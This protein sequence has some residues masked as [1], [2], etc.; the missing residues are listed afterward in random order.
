MTLDPNATTAAKLD[1]LERKI[2]SIAR[3]SQR[4]NTLT[5]IFGVISTVLVGYWLYHAHSRFSNEVNPQLV[6][7]VGQKYIEDYLPSASA[8]LQ[9]SLE[10]NAPHVIDEG[11][12][13]LHAVPAHLEDAF[14][15]QVRA[16]LDE[17]MPK[18]EDRLYE[19]M[20]NGLVQAQQTAAQADPGKSDEQR[21][22]GVL[23]ALAVIYGTETSKFVDQIHTEYN[24]NAGN[25]INGLDLLAEGKNLTPQQQTQRNLVRDLLILAKEHNDLPKS[26]HEE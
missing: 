6:A 13:Q 5:V 21:F 19:S 3:S 11:E 24:K 1:A 14:R 22:R 2:T 12:K 25:I 9:D 18:V 4:R 26:A 20:K 23:G 7:S 8:Q 17:E 15:T 10:A 16:T